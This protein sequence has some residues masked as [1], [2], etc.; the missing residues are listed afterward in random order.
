MG[1]GVVQ[2]FALQVDLRAAHFAA[3][4]RGVVD[5]R[6]AADEVL[7]LVVELGQ[8]GRVVLE[9]GIR[10]AQLVD[11]VGERFAR[12]GAA[13]GA[14]VAAGVG[15]LVVLELALHGSRSMG[16]SPNAIGCGG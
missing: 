2:V 11:R 12:E 15:L 4:A 16:R 10:V 13:V 14:E 5:R 9:L 8:E 7:Q 6:G 3:G 1:A